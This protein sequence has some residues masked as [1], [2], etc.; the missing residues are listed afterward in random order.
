[1][2]LFYMFI[3]EANMYA[4]T[5]GIMSGVTAYLYQ[6]QSNVLSHIYDINVMEI[7]AIRFIPFIFI[8]FIMTI[9]IFDISAISSYDTFLVL[10]ISILIIIPTFLSQKCIHLLKEDKFSYMSSLLPMVVFVMQDFLGISHNGI[11]IY[12]LVGIMGLFMTYEMVIK[13][14]KK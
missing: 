8:L 13:A 11:L 6:K 5:F 14:F 2:A 12:I 10:L 3:S 1:M 7:L 9:F 4:L